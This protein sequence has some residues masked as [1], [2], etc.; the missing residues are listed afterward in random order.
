MARP[1]FQQAR[2]DREYREL[3]AADPDVFRECVEAAEAIGINHR[4]SE[5]LSNSEVIALLADIEQHLVSVVLA[6]RYRCGGR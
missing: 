2:I 5:K 4:L 6:A 3:R 1:A